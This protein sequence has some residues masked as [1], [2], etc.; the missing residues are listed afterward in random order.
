MNRRVTG[1]S[2]RLPHK[3]PEPA[4]G[5]RRF[6]MFG[7]IDAGMLGLAMLMVAL[8]VVPGLVALSSRKARTPS[9]DPRMPAAPRRRL[10]FG[11]A[12]AARW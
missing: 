3:R 9:F 5:D 4:I 8:G 11:A 1:R 7:A 6:G 2:S 12:T 10:R